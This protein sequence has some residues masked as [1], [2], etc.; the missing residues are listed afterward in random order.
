M[1]AMRRFRVIA[2]VFIA[3]GLAVP[4]AA[5]S[6][7]AI[8]SVTDTGGKPIKGATILAVNPDAYPRQI[9]STTDEKGRF[10]IIGLRSGV[11][12]FTAQAPGYLASEGTIPVR[13]ATAGPPVRFI[14]QRSPEPIPGALSKDIDGEIAAATALRA[15]GRLDQ[16]LTKYQEIQEKNP[17]L[18]MLH[19][20][21]AD[22]YRQKAEREPAGAAR[23][24]LYERAIAIYT[25]MLKADAA[26]DRAKIELA[27]TSQAAGHREAAL[28]GLQE[29]ISGNPGSVAAAEAYAHLARLQQPN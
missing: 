26:N 13:S 5:Q 11:W 7:R 14:L 18:S 9:T 21:V 1:P 27:L 16:A 2:A 10:G 3:A 8:G 15:E 6:G 29:V 28:K 22:V 24:A 23:Q 19:L 17:K 20:V 12:R 4:A 25:D